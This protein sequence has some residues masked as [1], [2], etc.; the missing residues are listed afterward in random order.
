MLFTLTAAYANESEN[1]LVN[2]DFES[3]LLGTDD[4]WNFKQ[5]GGWLV[6]GTTKE[7]SADES[8]GGSSS[9]K[10]ANATAGQCV[11]LKSDYKYTLT[12][13]VKGASEGAASINIDDGTAVY[14]DSGSN[15][16]QTESI[17]V[18][19]QWQQIT[20]EYTCEKSQ[21]YVICFET[22]DG[23][24]VYFD[25]AVLVG[26][27][28]P[29]DGGFIAN[30]DFTDGTNGWTITGST[31][32]TVSDGALTISGADYECRVS[33]TVTVAENGI[34]TLTAYAKTPDIEGIA[35]LYAKTEGKTMASTAIPQADDMI[36]ITVP[37]VTVDNG[38]CDVG[39]YAEGGAEVTFSKVSL[40]KADDTGTRVSFLK[41]GEI[42]KLTYVEDR[43]GVFRYA[44]GTEG[45]ALQIMAENGFN[46]ARIRVLNNPGKNSGD[47]SW[48]LPEYYQSE[49]DCLE[50]ARRAHDKG[51]QILFSFAYADSWSDGENQEAP[52]YWRKD[53]AE[54]HSDEDWYEY[55][56][57]QVY[58]YT[59]DILQKLVNQGTA[60]EYVS[61]GN[62][63]Q[64]GLFYGN[65][66][67]GSELYNNP[68]M[69][70][71]F[72]KAGAKAVREV[73]PNAKIVL[74]TDNGGKVYNRTNYIYTLRLLE[75]DEDREYDYFDVIGASYYPYYNSDV[76]VDT[77]V[78]EFAKLISEF[79]K[80]V[81]IMET[82]YN[83]NPTKP[84]G[85]MGQ[86][87]NNG[88]Y[89]DIYGETKNGQRAFLTELYAK[90]KQTAGGRC[91][92]DLYWDPV[93]IYDGGVEHT[94]DTGI[95]WAIN[96]E[97]DITA[98][99][100]VPNS[101][102]FDFDG[103]AVV[104]QLAMKYN[105]NQDDKINI[106]G[107]VTDKDKF[108]AETAMNFT[109]NDTQYTVKTDKYGQ[110]IISVPYPESGEFEISAEGFEQT[111]TVD[112]PYDGVLLS[113]IDFSVAYISKL[114]AEFDTDGNLTYKADYVTD[115]E[116]PI[117]YVAA[118]DE[119][120]VL[121]ACKIA[122]KAGTLMTA[123]KSGTYTVKVFLWDN[124]M[125][126]I[127]KEIKEI[128]AAY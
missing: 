110:Y 65:Y 87:K 45:D 93:M 115:E 21:D 33:Q 6:A 38:K 111:Y 127:A 82:G 54:N 66:A 114:E 14:P 26:A 89:T 67:S 30:G 19:T 15:V 100:V 51:M 50:L 59:K 63:M 79:D 34:Y 69:L 64:A 61:I 32:A 35:Y 88:Y 71:E 112:A 47:E 94:K 76:S 68:T 5:K 12:V 25:N 11:S 52:F 72:I 119:N 4:N 60:P 113:E 16:W 85:Y 29:F 42:S 103:K 43:G 46:L 36:R 109:V 39:V 74:H 128:S 84:D 7:I 20:V 77:V 44:D 3:R 104:G 105:T 92:G 99:N 53:Y 17:S 62:E 121:A 123:E 124:N 1:L 9:L 80:D 117:L 40:V 101:T 86:L 96:G 90:L 27:E 8:H 125:K 118:Y 95:G 107:T 98:D 41:G 55:L 83:W 57:N 75:A 48:Y 18:T 49:D 116:N 24:T 126:P 31:S 37:A 97:S 10:L 102:I 78:N 2:G 106:T 22:W 73:T 23:T 28:I 120:G 81:I 122:S 108:V 58:E 13:W 70:A 56:E 91:I